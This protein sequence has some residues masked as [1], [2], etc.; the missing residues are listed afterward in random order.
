[1]AIALLDRLVGRL[2]KR[3]AKKAPTKAGLPMEAPEA[4]EW[5]FDNGKPRGYILG[6]TPGAAHLGGQISL[7]SGL[8]MDKKIEI[9]TRLGF[10]FIMFDIESTSEFFEPQLDKRIEAIKAARKTEVGVHYAWHMELSDA[11]GEMWRYWHRELVNSTL[12]TCNIAKAKFGLIHLSSAQLPKFLYG[13]RAEETGHL[14]A[15]DGTNLAK[16]IREKGTINGVDM[17]DWFMAIAARELLAG[18]VIE[19]EFFLNL[20]RL[21]S[22]AEYEKRLKEEAKKHV[23][24]AKTKISARMKELQ[25]GIPPRPAPEQLPKFQDKLR[26]LDELTKVLKTASA[27]ELMVA[28]KFDNE[29]I[30]AYINIRHFLD[31]A[32][33]LRKEY[34]YWEFTGSAGTESIA[35]HAVAKWMWLSE[36]PFYRKMVG[37][38]DPDEIISKAQEV[39]FAVTPRN[40]RQLVAAVAGEYI[41]GHLVDAGRYR[42]NRV[43]KIGEG[44]KPI[45][46][47]DGFPIMEQSENVYDYHKNRGVIIYLE[48]AM[49][50]QRG[51]EGEVR[52]FNIID[53]IKLVNYID[54]GQYVHYCPDLEHLLLH[55]V[56]V[57]EIERQLKQLQAEGY[58]AAVV[59]SMHINPPRPYAGIHAV[60]NPISMDVLTL[61][62]IFK[63]FRDAG[64]KDCIFIWERGSEGP[65]QQSATAL[66]TIVKFLVRDTPIEALPNEFFGLGPEFEAAQQVAVRTHGL[67]PIQGL[68]TVPEEEWSLLSSAVSP[69]RRAIWKAEELR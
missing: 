40:L 4:A 15:P 61:Y 5:G 6:V 31:Y 64:M 29:R 26:E 17:Q 39:A 59:T 52:I 57:E 16:W 28:A 50:P 45:Y 55:H 3:E 21:G 14:V 18:R 33:F 20:L 7:P 10:N 44:G 12:G 53:G 32:N 37:D 25:A 68:L 34:E 24:E 49:P 35:Y 36:N 9:G 43:P 58:S 8:G 63:A 46:G 69:E 19:G 22:L 1:M 30:R 66:R 38:I 56:D 54:G 62:K 67:E 48:P 2:Q 51:F 42:E 27:E 65:P 60:I 41:K 11:K 23:E 47:P 13:M